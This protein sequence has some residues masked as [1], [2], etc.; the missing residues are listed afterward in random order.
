M[1]GDGC[2]FR[3]FTPKCANPQQ[4]VPAS[5]IPLSSPLYHL[6]QFT[7][8]TA[9]LPQFRP[10][11]PMDP[12]LWAKMFQ[13]HAIQAPPANQI[14]H[15]NDRSSAASSHVSSQG[16]VIQHYHQPLLAIS[17]MAGEEQSDS[18]NETSSLS[19]GHTPMTVSPT[20]SLPSRSN[21]FS[22]SSILRVQAAQQLRC[23]QK[24]SSFCS[25]NNNRIPSAAANNGES[26]SMGSQL[27][28][29]VRKKSEVHSVSGV[30]PRTEQ[31][32]TRTAQLALINGTSK[33]QTEAQHRVPFQPQQPLP[34]MPFE[35]N[36]ANAPMF[37]HPS[38]AFRQPMYS[39]PSY[40]HL[41]QPLHPSGHP[42]GNLF[43]YHNLP[44]VF[45]ARPSS[46]ASGTS[47]FALPPPATQMPSPHG[48]HP[49]LLSNSAAFLSLLHQQQHQ[50][51]ECCVVC[52]DRASGHHYGVQSCEGCKGFFRRSVQS[53]QHYEC[54]KNNQCPVDRMSRN[55]CQKCRLEKCL[56]MGM[57]QTHVRLEKN[58]KRKSDSEGL[59][60]TRQAVELV[61]AVVQ[62][63][64]SSFLVPVREDS[65]DKS[66]QL[67]H[68]ANFAEARHRCQLFVEAIPEFSVFNK[69][70]ILS[71]NKVTAILTVLTVL[72]NAGDDHHR[73]KS[74]ELH[75]EQLT[76]V[77]HCF[78][79]MELHWEE[80]AVFI[81]GM[82][83][84]DGRSGLVDK[85]YKL[86]C[87]G[88]F[89]KLSDRV[90][91]DGEN[92]NPELLLP[93]QRLNPI[94]I[95]NMSFTL[96]CPSTDN[97]LQHSKN[98]N[99]SQFDPDDVV[100]PW[101]VLATSSKG[102]DYDKLIERF[103]CRKLTEDLVT[104]IENLTG[105]RAHAM[106]R[107]G[108]FFA[109]RDLTPILD[110]V[111]Q[112]KPFYLYTGRGPSSGSLHLGHLI[113]FFFC[114]SLQGRVRR[115]VD[116][117]GFCFEWNE[118]H[119]RRV[120]ITDDEKF[121]WK[122]MDLERSKK[123]AVE[124]VKDIISV[125]FDPQKTFIF[126]D[127]EYMRPS[128]YENVLKVWKL[129]TNNQ[130]RAI[131][132]F[133][134]EDS[135]GKSAFP[136]I[137]AAP[138]FSSSFPEIFNGR[139]DVPCLIPCA[140]D[141]DPYFRMCR[142][143]APRLKYQK[144]SLIYS[145]FLPALQGAQSKMAASDAN[146]CIYLDDTP[147][148]IKEKINKYAFSGGKDTKEE[149]RQFG[150]DCDVDT[151]FQFLRYFLDD[152]DRLEQIRKDY[153]SGAMFS[154]ELKAIAIEIVQGIV[155]EL[156]QRRKNVSDE[157]VRE[158]TTPRKLAFDF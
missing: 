103:G 28:S 99:G 108:L 71:K 40:Y 106:L 16:A 13:S 53:G 68:I 110:R 2:P 38:S 72:L 77:R 7:N 158:F 60:S 79:D 81:S 42:S 51:S 59:E 32:Q 92:V 131:F 151:S 155:C 91:E 86:L 76:R 120:Q 119:Y 157:V 116:H 147:K 95:P 67:I 122:D 70:I 141:Q 14:K 149:H 30:V 142:D 98:G 50:Q 3:L 49:L 69:E 112:K 152:D 101:T 54:A 19:P 78:S 22:V 66:A 135:M 4:I 144:P 24:E 26:S 88:L 35:T 97:D 58:R 37:G 87:H 6:P 148:K 8:I 145:T 134:G 105:K 117:P 64:K 114:K 46:S 118:S 153:S 102:V 21:S 90:A 80:I 44:G 130:S 127:T 150:G 56:K 55:R 146:S 45:A 156:Q 94:Y 139:R 33:Q 74:L 143:V 100:T 18:G 12:S 47:P 125:G 104:R 93:I 121:L 84:F 52:G 123:I 115:S 89:V 137:E 61:N 128:F 129:V 23:D 113:P 39:F 34:T 1:D 29:E 20:H 140:I 25:T 136:A 133:T 83:T 31:L 41:Q 154:G 43:P 36:P 96:N 138:C 57:Q 109:H 15:N 82:M 5:A 126:L 48:I 124:N 10:T 65:S 132:G 11:N 17:K 62:A 75:E 85:L 27:P 63:F 107:R 9:Q 73:H 111:E